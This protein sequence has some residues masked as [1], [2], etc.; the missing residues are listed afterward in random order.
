[1]GIFSNIGKTG[2]DVANVA[3]RQCLH[4]IRLKI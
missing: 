1:M 2:K 3:C 4:R